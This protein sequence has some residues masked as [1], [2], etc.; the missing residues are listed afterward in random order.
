MHSLK[1]KKAL[2]RRPADLDGADAFVRDFRYGFTRISDGAVE[3][4]GEQFVWE[5]TSNDP[6][7]DLAG[8]DLRGPEYGDGLVYDL[9]DDE[10]LELADPL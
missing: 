3:A 5:A 4:L 9:L 8:E 10:P 1:H 2:R 6:M 7:G